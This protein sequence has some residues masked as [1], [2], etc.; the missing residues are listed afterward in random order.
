MLQKAIIEKKLDKYSMKVRIPVYNKVKSDPTATP[1]DELYTATIQTLPGCSP[2]YQEGDVV[3]VDFENDDLSFPIIIGLLYREH[4]PQGSTDITADSLVVNVNTNLSEN[5]LI[6]EVTPDSLKKLNDKYSNNVK[7]ISIEYSLSNYQ[8]HYDSFSNWSEQ[9]PQYWPGKFMWQRTTVTYEDGTIMRSMTCIQGA[10]GSAGSGATIEE[11]YVKYAISSNGTTPPDITQS[12]IWFLNPPKTTDVN[13]YLWSWTYTRFSDGKTNSA[14]GVSRVSTNSAIVYLYKR[15]TNEITAID[16]TENITYDFDNKKLTA[17]P[18]G[19]SEEIPSGS[20]PL[21]VTAATASSITAQAT[22]TPAEWSIPT[23]FSTS[24]LNSRT[25]LLYKRY[26]STPATPSTVVTYTFSTGAIQPASPDGWSL[27]IPNTDGNPCYVTQATAIGYGETYTIQKNA[28]SA[29]TVLAKDGNSDYIDQP[30]IDWYIVTNNTNPPTSPTADIEV[31]SEWTGLGWTQDMSSLELSASNKYLWNAEVTHYTISGYIKTSPHII[32]TFAETG[33][34]IQDIEDKF[35]LNN[36]PENP[37][38]KGSAVWG[39]DPITPTPQNKYLWKYEIIHYTTGDSKETTPTVISMYSAPGE[40]GAPGL[41]SAAV[42]LYQR[43]TSASSITKPTGTLTYTFATGTLSGQLGGW[44]QS[45]PASNGNPCFVIQATAIGTGETDTISPSEWSNITEL[46]S[47]G[48]NGADGKDG[49]AGIGIKTT[50]IEYAVSDN[51]VQFPQSGWQADIPEVAQGKFLWT[52]TTIEYTNNTSSVSYSVSKNGVNGADGSPG[53]DGVGIKQTTISYVVSDSG[54]DIPQTGWK[55]TIDATGSGQY[56][57]TRTVIE[58]TDDTSSTSYSVSRNGTNGIDGV[59]GKDGTDGRNSAVVY[60]YKRANSATIDWTNDLI[61][62]F[63]TKSITNVPKGWYEEIPSGTAPIFVTA[64]TA[65]SN[66]SNDSIPPSEWATPV[67]LA[68]NGQDGAPGTPGADGTN[69]LNTASIFLYKRAATDTGLTKPTADLTYTFA[70][71]ELSGSLAGWSRTIPASNGNP[72]FSIQATAVSSEATDTILPSEWSSIVKLV[73]DGAPGKD[74]TDGTDGTN[75]LNTAIVYL[76]KRSPTAATI[77]WAQ[78][79]TYSFTTNKLQSVPTGWHESIPDG[80]DP[81]YM[82]AATAS[83]I[84][85]TDTITKD[86]WAAPILLAKNGTDGQDGKPGDPGTSGSSAATVF[87]Y[88]RGADSTSITKPTTNLTYTFETGVLSGT[89]AGWSQTIPGSDGNPCFMIQATA[90][91]TGSTDIIEPSEWSEIIKL[92][93]DG[94]PGQNGT[95]GKDGTD[96]TN[97]VNTAIVYLYKRSTTSVTINWTTTLTY[98]FTTKKLTTIP[99]GWSS[100]IPSGTDPLYVTA[101]TAASAEN[102]DTITPDEWATPVI[103]AQNGQDGTDGTDGV[104]ITA[105]VNYYLAT[106]LSTDVTKQTEGWTTDIQTISPEKPYLW[107][108]EEVKYSNTLSTYTDPCIIGTYG[109]QGEQGSAGV[110]ITS[111]VEYYALS[112][113][114]TRPTTGWSTNLP[115]MDATNRYLW[116]YSVITYT[117]GDTSGSVTD[118]LIIGV[119]GDSVL[120]VEIQAD[121]GTLFN[122]KATS[123]TLSADVYLGVK[124]LTVSATGVVKDGATTMGQLNWF[125][126]ERFT[127]NGTSTTFDLGLDILN[128]TTSPKVEITING[129]TTTE[130]TIVDKD[131]IKFNTAPANESIILIQYLTSTSDKVTVTRTDVRGQVV[132]ICKVVSSSKTLALSEVTIKDLNDAS[133]LKSWYMLTVDNVTSVSA[134]SVVYDENDSSVV[135]TGEYKHKVGDT[136]EVTVSFTWQDSAPVVNSNTVSKLCYTFQMIIFSD[137][138]CTAGT[139]ERSA[140]FDAGVV[141]WLQAQEAK[142]AADNA[143][144]SADNAQNTAN[145]ALDGTHQNAENIQHVQQTLTA[146]DG[147]LAAK[148]DTVTF[149]PY[150]ENIDSFMQFDVE[151]ST[152]T[153]GKGNFKQQMSPTKNSFMEGSTEVAYISNQELYINNATVNNKLSL[154]EQWVIT[155]DS[156]NGLIIKHI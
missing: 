67:I 152:M 134:P 15:S 126:K 130:F 50:T 18:A 11:T 154:D 63:D 29:P 88:K 36:D 132:I 98:N 123:T 54:T 99:A 56:L 156:S 83:S 55:D 125:A 39:N 8:D 111:I 90:I 127:G 149:T 22:I 49:E 47:D 76:Y 116:N 89:L 65:S 14:F 42:F 91:G 7:A 144:S 77:N 147:V 86:E 105:V 128:A 35:A 84:T 32:T 155:F 31:E 131:T 81:I 100:T 60:L 24:G 30:V 115:S 140:A 33:K 46:V 53:A 142:D 133:S 66:T 73:E 62:N 78:T 16:W 153:L 37:P 119:Y 112:T 118:A 3:I 23:L 94:A 48:K 80:T 109:T 82:T 145:D 57:W 75:G 28:W 104:S 58:Y 34:G 110:G 138:S 121:N 2:N 41:S 51:G 43:A 64:A 136:E 92:V 74:G 103:L 85:L 139:V 124:Q 93:E 52:R 21:Y 10:Q 44:K 61:Y 27:T 107:N 72:C 97:G 26:G 70:T 20:E 113:T 1:T 19:W 95:D 143:Q 25:V 137:N 12:G 40:E 38:A 114:T 87:L 59:D 5:T 106:N 9:A 135:P 13:P 45:I 102:T 122:T 151:N 96:G 120:S 148:L 71:G 6:G 117:N 150:K 108:Y 79:L 69:G 141:S 68:Q 146:I 101:A 17:A 4:M 129:T